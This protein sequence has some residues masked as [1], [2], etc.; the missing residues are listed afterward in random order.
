MESVKPFKNMT[1]E[2]KK[3]FQGKGCQSRDLD[4]ITN[5]SLHKP[6]KQ[7]GKFNAILK[8]GHTNLFLLTNAMKSSLYTS[9]A[10]PSTTINMDIAYELSQLYSHITTLNGQSHTS[11]SNIYNAHLICPIGPL[12]WQIK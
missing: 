12:H 1:W 7:T 8:R 2:R 10:P 6:C 5:R 4:V 3:R 9:S 11:F